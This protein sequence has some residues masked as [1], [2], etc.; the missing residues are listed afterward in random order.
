MFLRSGDV[1]VSS[2]E[3]SLDKVALVQDEYNGSVGSTGFFVLRPQTV[4]SGYL[5]ALT[6]SLVVREQMRC[7]ASGTILAAVPAKSLKNIIVPKVPPEKR[8][9]ISALI[10]QSH[11]AR[12]EAKALLEIAKRA[13]EI[14]IEEGEEKAMEFLG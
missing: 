14:A 9:E 1:I 6:K 10:L 12:R 5:L 11:A 13:V 8:S 4:E 2:V 7:E 3:G